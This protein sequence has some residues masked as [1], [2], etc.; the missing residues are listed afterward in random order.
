MR[1]LVGSIAHESNT[2]TPRC[3]A[4]DDF[5]IL[6][7]SAIW[8]G[9][10][11]GAV[12]GI[13]STLQHQPGIELV[14]SLVAHALPGGTVERHAYQELKQGLLS[15]A[16]DVDAACLFLHGAMRAEGVD[17]CESDL[18]NALRAT[19]GPHAPIVVALD[20]H[21][22]LVGSMVPAAD[23]LV[24]Y[25]TAPH[26]DSFETG[27][28]AA[29]I[30][31]RILQDRVRPAMGF[32]KLPIL[33][34]GE[35]AQT[36]LEP[37]ASM[38]RLVAAAEARPGVLSA[39]LAV[40]HIWADVPD[41]GIG[42]IVVT[43]GDAALAQSEADRLALAFWE[44]RGDFGL[45]AEAWPVDKAIQV[46][47]AAPEPTVFLSDSGDN[48]T[49]GGTSD[50][51]VMLERL[52]ARGAANVLVAAMWD[53][54]AVDACVAA[55]VSQQVSL[56]I[57]AKVDRGHGRPLPVTGVVRL[58]SDG[59]YYQ[60]GKRTAENRVR[61]GP[62]AVL[63]ID[64][65]DVVLSRNRI[66]ITELDQLRSLGLEPLAYRIVVLK[67]GYLFAPFQ[68]ISPRSILALSPGATNC[69]VSQL[70]YRRVRRPVY[71][72]DP[73]TSWTPQ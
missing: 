17:Y 47:M 60:S 30:L 35:M 19:M 69:D 34:P 46:A 38:M 72:L 67:V 58:L 24:A 56:S 23:A 6:R 20:M 50:V 43:D 62:I 33:L 11:S 44:R 42:V 2:F 13:V 57:G 18:L 25:H 27:V 32:A 73:D 54:E 8:S 16:S 45:S 40:A 53:S 41:Q 5:E 12:G 3:T 48:V 9:T 66:A 31:L 36:A 26:V 7:G 21:A 1:V 39:S 55:G 22:D 10:L 15:A 64:G 4:L 65:I 63:A 71:P 59:S 28:R 37:M 14:P 68:A 61:R 51:P 70:G 52:L 49:A 29:G